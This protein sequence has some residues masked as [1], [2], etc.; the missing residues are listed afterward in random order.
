MCVLNIN[1]ENVMCANINFEIEIIKYPQFFFHSTVYYFNSN[2]KNKGI[3]YRHLI[4]IEE[5]KKK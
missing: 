3:I 1:Y 5:E 4:R 2:K